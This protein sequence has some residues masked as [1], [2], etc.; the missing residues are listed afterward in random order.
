MRRDDL[1]TARGFIA[2][3]AISVAIWLAA[4][5]VYLNR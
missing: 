1:D 4:M 2:G 5:I 3:C